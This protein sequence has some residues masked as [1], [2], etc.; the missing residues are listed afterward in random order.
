[1]TYEELV[2]QARQTY[3]R[4]DASGIDGHVAYQ[5]NITGEA[6]G[7]FYLE[8]S[9]GKVNIEPYEYFDR[10]V[11][12]TTTAETLI[13]IAM[14][15][16]DPVWA[17]TTGKLKVQGSIEKALLLKE[18][19]VS[20]DVSGEES[21]GQTADAAK[22]DGTEAADVKDASKE[23]GTE[24]ADVKDAAKEDEAEAADVK[25]AAKEDEAEA[26]DVKDAADEA[27]DNAGAAVTEEETAGGDCAEAAVTEAEDE[28]GTQADCA[29]DA[30]DA[31][32]PENGSG[33]SADKGK[34][35]NGTGWSSRKKKKNGKKN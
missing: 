27:A 31:V 17:Y 23:D 6:E 15:K 24:A 1:M 26:A 14:G 3:G 9:D 35:R 21:A 34:G 20:E 28:S 32:A 2:E 29:K 13:K 22:E 25:G 18:L 8:V 7:A 16:L 12:F 30:E 5:F 33:E 4:A 10:D 11:L 19:S